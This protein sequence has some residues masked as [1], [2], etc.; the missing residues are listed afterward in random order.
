VLRLTTSRDYGIVKVLWNGLEVARD[1]DLW[2]GPERRIGLRELDL[3][4]QDLAQPALLQLVVTGH[5]AENEAPHVYFGVD[6]LLAKA[7]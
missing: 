6:C 5:A 7:K 4:E 2:G 3:G 1:V